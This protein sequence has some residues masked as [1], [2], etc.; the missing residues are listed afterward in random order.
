MTGA[1][2]REPELGAA[3]Y[4]AIA[5]ILHDAARITLGEGKVTLVQ[6]RLGR[7]LRQR[8]L[9]G[10]R[11]YLRLVQEDP[12]ERS[13]MVAALTTNHTHFFRE[14]HHFDHFRSD[15]LPELKARAG[16][17]PL[18]LWSA[19]CSSGEE[20][21]TLAMCLLGESRGAAKWALEGDVRLLAT[22]ISPPVVAATRQGFYPEAATKAVPPIYRDLW[23]E[24]VE[25]GLQMTADVRG[26]VSARELNLFGEWPIRRRFD[27][28]FCRN[29]MIYFDDRAKAE[30]ERRLVDQLQPGGTLYI[31]HS[32]RLVGEAQTLVRPCGHTIYRKAGDLP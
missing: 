30:L 18:R 12:D 10:F 27:V 1:L 11:D 22:D 7:R 14:S 3:E 20:V 9:S 19:G 31:G 13:T 21:Y 6:S 28:I 26:L 4:K 32:E 17:R 15:V 16:R 5:G 23:M 8:G 2:A 25:G 24:E 29:V